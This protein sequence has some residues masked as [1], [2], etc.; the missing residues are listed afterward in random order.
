LQTQLEPYAQ[1]LEVWAHQSLPAEIL[2]QEKHSQAFELFIELYNA[3]N[4]TLTELEN[5]RDFVLYS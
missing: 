1:S 2:I 5:L 4:L 3:Y